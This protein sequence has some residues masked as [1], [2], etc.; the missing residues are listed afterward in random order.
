MRK[1]A[2]LLR[3]IEKLEQRL[4]PQKLPLSI[5]VDGPGE[6]AEAAIERHLREHPEDRGRP[7]TTVSWLTRPPDRYRRRNFKPGAGD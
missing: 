5:W 2:G 6:P 4:L 7:I 3:R 1:R